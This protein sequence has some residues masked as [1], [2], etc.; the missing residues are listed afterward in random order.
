MATWLDVFNEVRRPGPV[1][2][3]VP[4]GLRSII[5]K[6]TDV[7]ALEPRSYAF[8]ELGDLAGELHPRPSPDLRVDVGEVRL[9]GSP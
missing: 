2:V 3:R 8:P 4:L 9:H 5:E 7:D 6:A 1:S